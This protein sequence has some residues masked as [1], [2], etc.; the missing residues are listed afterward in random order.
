[1]IVF[2]LDS[3]LADTRHRRKHLPVDPKTGADWIDYHLHCEHDDLLDTVTLID[4]LADIHE[5]VIVSA[6][7]DTPEV[8]EAT[9]NWLAKREIEYSHLILKPL[10]MPLRDTAAWKAAM[11]ADLP[12]VALFVD[13]W[14]PNCEAVAR[15]GVPTICVRAPEGS[16]AG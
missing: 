8:R 15:L 6:R 14:A 13:D 1:M 11:V 2:D 10:D 12:S 7:P 5:I 4:L 3:T 16:V 9:V